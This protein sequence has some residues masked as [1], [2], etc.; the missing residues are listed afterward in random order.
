MDFGPRISFLEALVS[1]SSGR[2]PGWPTTA[3]TLL[4]WPWVLSTPGWVESGTYLGPYSGG[5]KP[6]TNKGETRVHSTLAS[7]PH[8]NQVYIPLDTS[9]SV[10]NY[11]PFQAFLGLD[12]YSQTALLT[13]CPHSILKR[14]PAKS[15]IPWSTQRPEAQP[16]LQIDA[17]GLR[18]LAGNCSAGVTIPTGSPH[19]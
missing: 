14:G 9:R 19:T 3:G 13:Q 6:S 15:S 7:H 1:L 17:S 18:L 11:I 4:T 2:F 10:S 16:G 8:L 5:R 12:K